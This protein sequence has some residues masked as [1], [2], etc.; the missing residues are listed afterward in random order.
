MSPRPAQA[1]PA[2]PEV[3]T[4]LHGLDRS[5]IELPHGRIDLVHPR[6]A[7]ARLYELNFGL[8]G[9]DPPYWAEPW[10]AGVE[11]ARAVSGAV[12]MGA[13]VLELGCGLALPSRTAVSIAPP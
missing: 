4:G 3:P 8:D 11:L 5:S 12:P 10:P 9:Q 1:D 7:M 2:A 6:D 13:R